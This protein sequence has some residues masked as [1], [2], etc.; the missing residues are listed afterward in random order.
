MV[1][2]TGHF[3]KNHFSNSLLRQI[4]YPDKLGLSCVLNYENPKTRILRTF[5][6]DPAFFPPEETAKPRGRAVEQNK[7]FNVKNLTDKSQVKP[8]RSFSC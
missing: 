5:F 8:S 7:F 1:S 6:Q 3:Q 4:L 2:R